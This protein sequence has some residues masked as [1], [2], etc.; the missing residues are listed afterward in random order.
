M[1]SCF[2]YFGRLLPTCVVLWLLTGLLGLG[3]SS[4]EEN[5]LI[6]PAQLS[7]AAPHFS[8]LGINVFAA[9]KSTEMT[10]S[11]I[12][13]APTEIRVA[14]PVLYYANRIK[15][16]ELVKN[17]NWQEAKPLLQ[18]LTT[19]F[20]DDGDTWFVLG[21]TYLELKQWR[22]AIDALGN[23]LALGTRLFGMPGGGANPNDMMIR[24]A[25]AY[26][27][28]GDEDQAIYWINQALEARWDDRPKLAGTSFFQQGKNPNFKAFE[29]SEAFQRAAGSYLP[30]ELSRDEGWRYDLHYLASEIKRLHV[31]PYHSTSAAAFEE[32]VNDVNRRIPALSDKQVVFTFMQLLG[33]LGNGHNFIIPAFGEKGSFNQLPMQFYWFSD[34]LFVV[35][36]SEPYRQWIGHKVEQVGEM[37]TLKALGLIE[38]INPRDNE[39]QQR[40]LAP[41]YFGLP[42]VLEG[43]GIVD[44]AD[45]VSLSL[46]DSRGARH[47]VSPEVKPMSFAGFPKLPGLS[48][49]DSPLYLRNNND[50]YWFEKLPKQLLYVQ[51]NDVANKESQSLKQFSEQIQQHIIKGEVDDMVLDLRHNSGGDGSLNAPM[52]ATTVLFKA[53]RREGKLFVLIGRNTFSAAHNLVMSISELTDAVLVGEPSGSRP[54]AIS[55]AGW[56][57]LPYSKQTG[58]ISSQFHQYGA[59]E[60]HRIWIAPHVPVSLS[61]EQYFKGEDPVMTAIIG[62]SGK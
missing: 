31:H 61:S 46:S 32:K 5:D 24:L 50:N 43:L 1:I 45:A 60:D 4:A 15:A 52:V 34:G 57:N 54:N 11:A 6:D 7:A 30:N 9:N 2:F 37:S 29:A 62:I 41:Y 48:T 53:L 38:A 23:A 14:D 20:K 51:F 22:N 42:S 28:M 3:V 35:N 21:L 39:M 49:A 55:E 36:A 27:Q 12:G 56:F 58:L 33:A 13:R 16:I 25:E 40:W 10:N 8:A 18:T 59:P 47:L 44:K 19:E 17:K 26:G